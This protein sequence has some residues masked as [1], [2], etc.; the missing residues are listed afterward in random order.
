MAYLSLITSFAIWGLSPIYWKAL[1][2]ID[3]LE[4]GAY[5][6]I[7][8]AVALLFLIPPAKYKTLISKAKKYKTL[9][10]I[11]CSCMFTNI[12]L[13]IYAVNTDQI[14]QASFGYFL[15]PLVSIT[16]GGLVL[17]EKLTK[18]KL[19]AIGITIISLTIKFSNFEVF[20]WV[21]IALAAAFSLYGL[22][23]KFIHIETKEMTF[24]EMSILVIPCT[25]ILFYLN[26]T[27]DLSLITQ[28]DSREKMILLF[29]WA[30]TLL[31]FLFFSFGTKTIPLNIVGFFQ[32]LSPSLQFILGYLIYNELIV[33]S[34][35]ISFLLIWCACGMV[36]ISNIKRGKI[37]R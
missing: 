28:T 17:K 27:Q 2:S 24:I 16:L 8:S 37:A 23:K 15:S 6:I 5:R 7:L 19:I 3:N 35:W 25:F 13:F 32:Y 20:P 14:L 10:L 36:A 33:T 12:F 31:P 21:S 11:S 4:L 29:C 9:L 34:E 26:N 30:P 22:L 1:I 18:I